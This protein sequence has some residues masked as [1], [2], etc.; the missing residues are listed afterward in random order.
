MSW[1]EAT[2]EAGLDEEGRDGEDDVG[3]A[4]GPLRVRRHHPRDV[5][6]EERALEA[7]A[8]PERRPRQRGVGAHHL[9]HRMAPSGT[10]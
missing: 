6:R 4:E 5:V 7:D 9:T 10:E 1:T 8:H 3:A 2:A